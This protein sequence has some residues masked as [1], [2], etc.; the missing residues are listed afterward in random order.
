MTPYLAEPAGTRRAPCH[1]RGDDDDAL[2]LP[3]T[4]LLPGPPAVGDLVMTT[5]IGR[6]VGLTKAGG[7]LVEPV[8]LPPIRR[9]HTRLWAGRLECE[10]VD[11]IPGGR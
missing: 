1:A 6:V 2:A 4:V 3:D 5:V 8:E 11:D 10:R 7:I 9:P